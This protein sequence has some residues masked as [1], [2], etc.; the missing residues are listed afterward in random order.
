M[1]T[2]R[3][4]WRLLDAPYRKKAIILI[5]MMII[6]MLMEA[7]GIGMVVPVMTVILQE[8]IGV[9]FPEV[10]P[11][12]SLLGDPSHQELI[13]LSIFFLCFA[14]L[15]KV[16][17]LA[18]LSWKQSKFI[19]GLQI[20]LSQRL[21]GAYLKQPYK[22]FLQNHSSQLVRNVIG[23]VQEF[24][25]VGLLS[26]LTILSELFVVTGVFVLLAIVEPVGAFLI[27][28]TFGLS[29]Y[30]FYVII[31]RDLR[32]WGKV[33]QASDGERIKY[34]Q[35][36]FEGI[37]L[38]KSLGIEKYF[39]QK[40]SQ[41]NLQSG[42][43]RAYQTF[44]SSLP[45]LWIE[46]LAILGFGVLVVTM[47]SWELESANMI[48]ILSL[49]A[50]AAF[51]VVP[52]INRIMGA[53]QNVRYGIPVV[54]TIYSE[55]YNLDINT[56]LQDPI[57]QEIVNLKKDIKL[58]NIDFS[59]PGESELTLKDV[60]MT[61]TKGN[62]VGI[63]GESG[64]GKSTIVD[65]L[66]G[67]LH[68]LEGRIMLDGSNMYS[69]NGSRKIAIGYIPQAVFIS[70]DTICKNIALGIP[71]EKI[72]RERIAEVIEEAQLDHFVKQQEL[73]IDSM[74]GERG[75]K[76][77]GGERQR[78]G[79]ARALYSQPEILVLDEPTSALDSET[80]AKVMEVLSHLY[81]NTTVIL[82]THRLET[83]KSC[84]YVYRMKG[85]KVCQHGTPS[86]ILN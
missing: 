35:E 49:F 46:F 83:V 26:A 70:D 1:A 48:P 51:R 54:N 19:F 17:F 14:Y 84:D 33:R 6:G 75:A 28:V 4:I 13:Y 61:I 2:F 77:S 52:S 68:P 78:I 34:L 44:T 12:L 80:E 20:E 59:Y 16:L 8:D 18:L 57:E 55:I 3:K 31:K 7:L 81:R 38:V 60:N 69:R 65:I 30:L 22:F 76:V 42:N 72:D 74:L 63:I 66:L 79:I 73:G 23:E 40:Y 41:H 39:Y 45:R 62:L 86:E 64:S 47:L 15:L 5:F 25:Q 85:G 27:L 29:A 71:D 21:L 32:K 67:L 11:L 37:K 10:S 43:S 50:M 58:C 24:S 56:A 53:V 82:I 9:H 36:S